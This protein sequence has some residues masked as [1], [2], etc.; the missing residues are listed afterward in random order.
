MRLL[1]LTFFIAFTVPLNA[2][3]MIAPTQLIFDDADRMKEV[4]LINTSDSPKSYRLG[5]TDKIQLS[6]GQY[7]NLEDG[8]VSEHSASEYLRF[9]PRQVRLLPG[10]RQVVRVMKRNVTAL[11]QGDYRSHLNF[12]VLPE[13]SLD[14]IDEP[15]NGVRMQITALISYSIPVV[16]GIGQNNSAFEIQSYNIINNDKTST[17]TVDISKQGDFGIMGRL[18]IW[19]NNSTGSPLRIGTLN[20]ANIFRETDQIRYAIKTNQS[21]QPEDDLTIKFVDT[22]T[23]KIV[24]EKFID[25]G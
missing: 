13:R 16:F 15:V 4:V 9:T 5:F 22:S 8:K 7:Q 19:K 21:I 3:L 24:D 10:E 11:P 20:G 2:A 1:I 17:V 25:K 6:N 18:E 12:S 23:R 14:A